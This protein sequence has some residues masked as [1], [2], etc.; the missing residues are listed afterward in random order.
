M[1][2]QVVHFPHELLLGLRTQIAVHGRLD[3]E[4]VLDHIF[5]V[6]CLV[7]VGDSSYF[8]NCLDCPS[9]SPSTVFSMTGAMMLSNDEFRGAERGWN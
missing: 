3:L 8:P 7:S 9:H 2:V 5:E 4:Q 6:G 1:E